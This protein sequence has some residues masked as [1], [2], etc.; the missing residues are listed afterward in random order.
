M[1]K[2]IVILLSVML[3][4]GCDETR[5]Y[6][7]NADFEDRYWNAEEK[8]SFEFTVDDTANS[9]NVLCNVRHAVSYPYSRL[10]LKYTLLDSA[11]AVV[12]QDMASAYLFDKSTGAPQGNSGLGDIYDLRVP[13]LTNFKFKQ[14]GKYSV[15]FEQFMRTDSLQGVLAV[16]VRI[17]RGQQ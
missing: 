8:P 5:L 3:L 1:R 16:G 13:L 12:K 4:I 2:C 7:Q 10:F 14:K 15:T 11:K 17:E 9:Y 6:E